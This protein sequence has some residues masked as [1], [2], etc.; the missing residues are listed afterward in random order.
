MR[1]NWQL[2][3]SALSP[4]YCN[5]IIEI[6]KEQHL[7]DATIFADQEC[8]VIDNFRKTKICWMEDTALKS[9]AED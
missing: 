8:E 4:E 3:E 7:Q 2:W 1:Q 6:G 5:E 9:I